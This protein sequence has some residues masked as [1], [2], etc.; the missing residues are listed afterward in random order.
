[1]ANRVQYTVY[2]ATNLRIRDATAILNLA[3]KHKTPVTIISIEPPSID[4]LKRRNLERNEK[5]GFLIPEH[6]F[7]SHHARYYNCIDQF[8]KEAVYNR[9]VTFVEIDQNYE[10]INEIS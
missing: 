8:H 1:L 7:D 3:K 10:V 9:L 2:D 5:T 4:E 6:V